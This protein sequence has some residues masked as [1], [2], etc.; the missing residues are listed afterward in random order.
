MFILGFAGITVQFAKC[1]FRIVESLPPLTL[2][3]F[4]LWLAEYAHWDC[5]RQ[6]LV[7]FVTLPIW[8]FLALFAV[9]CRLSH[10]CVADVAAPYKWFARVTDA[11]FGHLEAV[12]LLVA[13]TAFYELAG[14]CED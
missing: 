5:S 8:L 4:P 9:S 1:T 13:C 14:H 2:V 11:T 6:Y 3:A 10:N 12:S 7:T